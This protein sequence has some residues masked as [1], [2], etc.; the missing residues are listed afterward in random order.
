SRS[1]WVNLY[2]Q[3]QREAAKLGQYN[4][5][6]F[7]HRRIRDYFEA[8]KTVTD[9]EG[10]EAFATIKRQT[11]IEQIYPHQKTFVEES[12]DSV[13]QPRMKECTKCKS[14]EY[15]NKSLVMLINE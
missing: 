4:H 10:Q 13:K 2:K 8:N 6:S 1:V 15:T 5:R 3:L 11:V 12:I 7:A 14:N 9:P